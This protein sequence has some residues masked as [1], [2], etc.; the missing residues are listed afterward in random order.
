MKKLILILLSV[1]V[2]IGCGSNNNN[3]K[4]Q[5]SPTASVLKHNKAV[6]VTGIAR[7]GKSRIT[8]GK[9]VIAGIKGAVKASAHFKDSPSFS[10]EIPAG[11]SY[12]VLLSVYPDTEPFK[13]TTLKVVVMNPYSKD[14]VVTRTTTAIAES[15][16]ALGGYTAKNM[17]QATRTTSPFPD[18]DTSVEG[19]NGDPTAQFGGWH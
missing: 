2:L 5:S 16:L 10:L 6:T 7:V 13:R 1:S 4:S 11:T 15:A 8:S 14:Q 17:M 12:P 3:S 9:V 18:R 19:F